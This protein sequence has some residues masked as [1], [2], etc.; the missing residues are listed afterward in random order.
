MQLQKKVVAT[1][2]WKPNLIKTRTVAPE[3][4]QH[5]PYAELLKLLLATDGEESD[6]VAL[7]E[8]LRDINPLTTN[9]FESIYELQADGFMGQNLDKNIKL[10]KV[11]YYKELLEKATMRYND[12]PNEQNYLAMKDRMIELDRLE[13]PED[14]GSI[15]DVMKEIEYELENEV[16]DGI[17]FYDQFNQILGGGLQNGELMIVAARPAVG[18]SAYAINLAIESAMKNKNMVIDF[19][20]LEM[21]KKQMVK[22]FL[23]RKTEINSYKLRNPV[24]KLSKT[25]KESIKNEG[26]LLA[27]GNLRIFDKERKIG[28]ISKIIRRRA[29]ENKENNYLVILDYLGLVR[30]SERKTD[31]REVVD[32]VSRGLK[33][34]T[35]DLNIPIIALSQLNRGLE[36]RIEKKPKL[37]DLRDSGS[38]EQDA[39][40]VAFLWEPNKENPI[41]D[42]YTELVIAKSRE[43]MT[44]DLKYR[45]I[46][47]KMVFE[48]LDY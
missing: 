31:Q 8:R 9:S 41:E 42:Q 47:S 11:R 45:F 43:G 18:K 22:R 21:T 29:Y 12:Q 23:S 5:K 15:L 6:P 38:I 19:F 46:K 26:N 17:K 25:E 28:D 32:E 40:I 16:D 10:L 44:G 35:T 4:F 7:F 2:L 1:L 36:N 13:E 20:T 24:L 48:E 14:D 37:S 34:L 3:W 33:E 30:S 39:N 27:N